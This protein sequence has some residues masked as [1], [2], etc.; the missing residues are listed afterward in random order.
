MNYLTTLLTNWKTTS[1]GLL[2]VL[3][4][5]AGFAGVT[6]AGGMPMS[7]EAAV[8][9]VLAGIAAIFAQDAIHPT[10]PTITP[11]TPIKGN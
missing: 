3:T 5:V 1:A 11:P 8:G 9:L 2:T 10:I 6:V 7:Q 4:G